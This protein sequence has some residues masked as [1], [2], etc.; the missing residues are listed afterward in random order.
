MKSKNS[1]NKLHKQNFL[2]TPE[3]LEL[4]KYFD[5]CHISAQKLRKQIKNSEILSLNI[6]QQNDDLKEFKKLAK[7]S[8]GYKKVII[9]G[10]GGSSLGGKTLC[11]LK[12]QNR[13]E[14]IESID[15]VT[16]NNQI[17]NI[18]FE[19]AFFIVI[20][21]SGETIETICQTLIII[22]QFKLRKIKN[23]AQQFIFITE[24]KNNSIG[25][26]AQKINA[27]IASHPT[28]IGGRYSCFSIVGLLPSIIAGVNVSDIRDGANLMLENFLRDD[29]IILSSAVQLKLYD[30]GYIN[31]VIMPYIDDFKNFTDWYRQLWAESLGKNS[32]GSTPINSMGTIDQHSQ[33]QLYLE[34]NRD[35]FFNFIISKNHKNDFKIKDLAGCETLFGGKKLSKILE[36]EHQTTIEVL[37]QKK[38][39]IRI[40]EIDDVNEKVIAGLMMQMFLETIII[41][42]AKKINP[43]DQPAVELRKNLAKEILKKN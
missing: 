10:V 28:K 15:P 22:E 8:E 43:F 6:V 41:A 40:F 24:S 2:N 13:I 39:P 35:K 1:N 19:N 37:N 16:I 38:L 17:K 34:G 7:L 26:I 30:Q 12:F 14:F 27:K 21:K 23:F 36:V 5:I 29:E 25:K 33:L 18:D 9:L 42:Y 3:R 20:S 4:K 32:F 11:S 31:N